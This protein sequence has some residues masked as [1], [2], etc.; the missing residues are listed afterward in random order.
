MIRCLSDHQL[1]ISI[2]ARPWV[3]GGRVHVFMVVTVIIIVPPSSTPQCLAML[4]THYAH[5]KYWG[6]A[7]MSHAPFFTEKA[8]QSCGVP[9]RCDSK[10]LGS[11][12]IS[13]RRM[14]EAPL[15]LSLGLIVLIWKLPCFCL[16]PPPLHDS[17]IIPFKA[18][19]SFCGGR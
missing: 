7:K 15:F 9:S 14:L 4:R 18:M 16:Y 1:I 10:S 19:I 5:V 6:H 12:P 8:A 13:R 2:P 3:P 11:D 17:I